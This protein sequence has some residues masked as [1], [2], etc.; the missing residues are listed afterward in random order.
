MTTS[1]IDTAHELM[2]E[3]V[4]GW[5]N[6]K[7]GQLTEN[8]TNDWLKT[9]ANES[10]EEKWAI[11]HV[12]NEATV[13][14]HCS[15]VLS[16]VEY[17]S[18]ESLTAEEYEEFHF[19]D[20][21]KRKKG[22]TV[23]GRDELLDAIESFGYVNDLQRD[24][25]ETAWRLGDI[26][27]MEEQM[28]DLAL[29]PIKFFSDA[30]MESLNKQPMSITAHS[31]SHKQETTVTTD[32]YD[33]PEV[34]DVDVCSRLTNYSK[35]TLYKMTSTDA[36]PCHRAGGKRRKLTFVLTEILD[37]MTANRQETASEYI[38]RMDRRIKASGVG[39][40]KYNSKCNSNHTHYVRQNQNKA[41]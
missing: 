36:I 35:S 39:C 24:D 20:E 19:V 21:Y 3:W 40:S 29:I 38:D 4:N 7:I 12:L 13:K 34:F 32:P 17:H 1:I 25:I 23:L 9:L 2:S 11:L 37:W 27:Y 10:Q 16:A 41:L 31:T 30:I 18:S 28:F 22:Y 5:L 6:G 14:W 8:E 33:Y 15:F 26:E